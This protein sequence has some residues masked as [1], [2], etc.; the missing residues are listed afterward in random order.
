MG[1]LTFLVSDSTEEYCELGKVFL[2]DDILVVLREQPDKAKLRDWLH[3]T[4]GEFNVIST[5]TINKVVNVALSWMRTHPDWR[6]VTEADEDYGDGAYLASDDEDAREYRE[7]F[8]EDAG[9]IYKQTG[10]VW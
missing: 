10:S 7:E 5:V 9:P 8:G 1:V 3:A 6:F 2:D 4:D